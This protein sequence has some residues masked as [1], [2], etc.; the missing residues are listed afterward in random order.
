MF[1][2]QDLRVPRS[3]TPTGLHDRIRLDLAQNFQSNLP[4]EEA[5]ESGADLTIREGKRLA[6]VEVKTGDP[7]LP[8]PS[9]TLAQMGLLAARVRLKL[10]EIGATEILP[11][12]VTNYNVSD[13]DKTELD[14]AGIKLVPIESPASGYDAKAFS[15]KFAT[16]VGLEPQDLL[17]K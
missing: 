13:A 8:L 7:D 2:T 9:S 5:D 11:V 14:Q 15:R 3:K 17:E 6:V 10:A 1:R 12:L 4:L 16:I